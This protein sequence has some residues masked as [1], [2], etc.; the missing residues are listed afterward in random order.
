MLTRAIPGSPARM[1]LGFDATD[2]QIA[3]FEHENGLDLPVL[4]QYG[5]WLRQ[6]VLHGDLGKSLVT[7][8]SMNQRVAETLPVTMEL[9]ALAFSFAVVLSLAL[10]TV[11]AVLEGSLADQA[12]RVSGGGRRFGAGVLARAAA[13]P[14]V[15]G[16]PALVSGRRRRAGLRR[17]GRASEFAGAARLLAR[18]VLHRDPEPHDAVEPRRGAR[19]GL[20]PHGAR[21]GLSRR[22]IL[23][24]AMKN[25]LVPVVTVAAMSFGYM[26]G[27]ALV[28][29]TVFNIGGMSGALL[30]AI[31]QRDFA[32]V[33]AVVLV[34]TLIFLVANLLADLANAWLDP[35]MAA[36][37]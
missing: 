29:E 10:G 28:I 1:V 19:S 6:L 23:L 18:R 17:A 9:V 34:F 25:A 13:H 24:Y 14:A 20:H 15:R 30:T 7:G 4:V 37:R 3:R 35:R 11:S 16:G 12:S 2:A 21:D 31:G 32:L 27:W 26:F 5:V 36:A 33:Q 8:L 22:L